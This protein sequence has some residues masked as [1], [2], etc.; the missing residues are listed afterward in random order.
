MSSARK[1]IVELDLSRYMD[2]CRFLQESLNGPEAVA[3]LNRQIL[4]LITQ[5]LQ[6]VNLS[7]ETIPYKST[8]DG[9][10]IAFDE[11]ENAV[12]FA[13]ALHRTADKE[14]SG[15]KVELARRHFRVGMFT[16]DIIIEEKRT[17]SGDL[18]GHEF[19]GTGIGDAVRLESKCKTGEI[20]IDSET[21]AEL[22][23]DSRKQ[24]GPEKIVKGKRPT[25]EFRA[26]SRRIVDPATWEKP[27]V[28]KRKL[29]KGTARRRTKTAKPSLSPPEAATA[30]P[31]KISIA[32]L[33]ITGEHLVGRERELEQ[34]DGAW[35]DAG[36]NVISL[37]A[38]GGV[39]KSALVNRW[40][41]NLATENYR[42]ARRVYGVSF[43]SQ[44]TRQTA[45]SADTAIDAALRWFD[46]P[47]PKAGS[48]WDKGERLA[49][50]V[51]Q[52]PTLLILDGLEPLQNPPGPDGGRLKD[53]ALQSLVRELAASNQGLCVITT[54]YRVADIDDRTTTTA[55][56]IELENL[57]D[58]AGAQLLRTLGVEGPEEEL[59][60]ASREFGG[61]GL[62][63]NL[64]GTYLHDVYGGDVRRRDEVSLLE[65]DVEQGGHAKRV[66]ESYEN[67]F[68]E[69][70]ELSVLRILGLFDRP[71][72]AKAV[73]ALRE[74]PPIPGLTDAVQE[75]TD[76]QWRQTLAKLR[77]AGLL[78]DADP[79][80]PDTL[81]A[82]PL[83][84]EHFGQQLREEHAQAWREGN[85]RL[86]EHY[87]A[88]APEF[89]DTLEEMAPLFAAVAHGCAAG[90]HQEALNDV[91]I[92][93]IQRGNEFHVTKKLGAFGADLAALAGLFE[94]PWQQPVAGIKEA[95]KA[96]ML[97]QAGFHLRALGRLKE[98]VQP[99]QAG[100]DADITREDWQNAAIAAGNLSELYNTM[101]DLKRG[102]EIA[103]QS[104]HL[105]DESGD[106]NHRM[107][108]RTI[109]ADALHQAGRA[110]EAETLFREAEEMQK[111]SQP[112]YPFLYS[113]RGY[114]YCD[115]LLG[116]GKYG[117]VQDRA[118]RALKIVEQGS[119]NLLDIALNHLS[120]GRAHLA[121]PQDSGTGDF[122]QAAEHLDQAVDGLRESGNQDHIPRGFL[123]RAALHRVR[124]AFDRSQHDLDEAMSIAERGGMGLFQTDAHLEYARLRLAMGDRPEARENLDKAK[125]MVGRMGYHRRDGAVA[126]LEEQLK[127]D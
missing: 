123:A 114:Q 88:V 58:E 25:E 27:A 59:R 39:G 11:A 85:N 53:P 6:I 124:K 31:E 80:D 119:R 45:V 69:G 29:P 91:Y 68:G 28:R 7:I 14:N 111:E 20:L 78:A 23:H 15:K 74:P 92:K 9:A 110:A 82:H 34:L 112:S 37:V 17:P 62:A 46:D 73:T 2:I 61:H 36:T 60:L 30:G 3:E 33:P 10:I 86:Y 120:L 67:W 35:A 93:R 64:L 54:R 109:N 104:V 95:D 65:S 113:I 83:V 38:W 66:M 115:L 55:P 75:L 117:E 13:I 48:P 43:Y 56:L 1:T 57:S 51:R 127:D 116:Q 4:N 49:R 103:Q 50:L 47:D 18:I 63:L 118:G 19:A 90:R 26:H 89:P 81:D 76:A 5:G 79:H 42:G 96:F 52:E 44:G 106:A 94:K 21:W 41:G 102:L 72:D 87:K 24:F 77:R 105:A 108:T 71:A 16:S 125:E 99:M 98:A 40:L 126:E 84:R 8:G 121:A 70:P 22:P 101:G 107:I 32:S 122:S 12:Q 100:L 97:A